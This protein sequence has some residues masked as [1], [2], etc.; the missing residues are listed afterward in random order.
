[1]HS[2]FLSGGPLSA[3]LKAAAAALACG[4]MVV[5]GA[6]QPAVAQTATATTLAITVGGKAVTSV[7]SGTVVTLTATVKA[8]GV[9]VTRGH[10][11]FC[12]ATEKYCT[13]AH[14]A[15]SAQLSSAGT[16]ALKFRPGV[17]SHSYKAAFAMTSA[18]K[19][20]ASPAEPL[21]VSQVGLYPTEAGFSAA[22][23]PGSYTLTARVGEVAGPA[24]TGTV[25]FLDTSDGNAVLATATL[26]AAA[27]GISF[28][29]SSSFS[30]TGWV[31][32]AAGDFNGD[33]LLDLVANQGDCAQDLCPMVVLLGNGDGSFTPA[34]KEITGFNAA[35]LAV[36]DFNGD[37]NQDL[38]LANAVGCSAT[39]CPV[40][41]LLGNGD[42]TFTPT[43]QAGLFAGFSLKAMAVG[44]FN[45]DGNQD[46]A[47][48]DNDG[49]CTQ[50]G[51]GEACTDS[52][53]TVLFGKGDGTF[54]SGRTQ[55]T[56]GYA[57]TAMASADWN[58]DR[59]QDFAVANWIGAEGPSN[60]EGENTIS[61]ELGGATGVFKA[62]AS[63]ASGT[64]P[65]AMVAADFNG[66]GIEDLAVADATYQCTTAPC[67]NGAVTVLLGNGDGTFSAVPESPLTSPYP[68]AMAALD[69]NGD[70][71]PD[72][73][74]ANKFDG[75]GS[76][77]GS[78]SVLLGNGDGTFT[79]AAA[80]ADLDSNPSAMLAGDFNG[81][82]VPDLAVQEAAS[83]SL[84]VLLTST[85]SAAATGT[86][87]AVLP[88]GSGIHE[89]V[90]SYS[91]DSN[92]KPSVS[93]PVGLSA[94]QATPV[95]SVS[96][97]A[98]PTYGAALT[99][100]ATVKGSEA[101]PTGTVYFYDGATELFTAVLDATGKA[102]YANGPF[103]KGG[104]HSI[105]VSYSG[106]VDYSALVS[107]VFSLVI[108]PA[109]PTITLTSS[110]ASFFEGFPATFTA[111]VAGVGA[112]PTGKV[113]LLVGGSPVGSA[114]LN[115]NGVA[116][117][118]TSA[119]TLGWHNVKA[120]YAG[121]G[122]YE[123]AAS[124]PELILVKSPAKPTITLTPSAS[125]IA[126]GASDTLTATVTGSNPN[127]TGAVEFLDGATELGAANLNA[128]GV[129]S[130]TAARLTGGK[131]SITASYQGDDVYPAAASSVV[132]VTVNRAVPGV[133]LMSSASTAKAGD[134]VTFTVTLS[135]SGAVP[136]APLTFL[137]GTTTLGTASPNSAG[138]A[139]YSTNKLGVG[140]HSITAFYVGG[141]NYLPETSG[142]V[143]VTITAQ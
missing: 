105:T 28:L 120:S 143:T 9:P 95:V 41:V 32:Y 63:P 132:S 116:I 47:V 6:A 85:E 141:E 114:T 40:V 51:G 83:H 73:V 78:I 135:G 115:S 8:G 67:A 55:V 19:A 74:V 134:T 7:A 20:S 14:L 45:G 75:S 138:V 117:I 56:A 113:T 87:I 126:Y 24:P 17:G 107:P 5:C 46:V 129:A 96:A 49:S 62:A 13:D 93:G 54:S 128:S 33:G 34:A 92:H 124:K 130:F 43:G 108:A 71:I 69:I 139:S 57:P 94:V 112:A 58:G 70:G 84:L 89:V 22:G 100:T 106:D 3:R 90:A 31:S 60:P 10:V 12:D 15:G 29:N 4:W 25:K 122:N 68:T 38:V 65:S 64:Q 30:L 80:S 109:A 110:T 42:G 21:T 27:K 79:S 44:D 111:Q 91:G 37:G 59:I 121:D 1:M 119:L 52:T 72:L 136:A 88:R 104:T 82:G 77:G 101:I 23:S 99:L 36:G 133:A 50:Q 35:A 118:S 48:M 127:P 86:G 103:L 97:S 131:H 18:D 11:N 125:T 26:G 140:T 76:G 53:V 39:A 61:V 16:A 2:H 66:D 142:A 81:D 102:V 137:D 98:N 123:A